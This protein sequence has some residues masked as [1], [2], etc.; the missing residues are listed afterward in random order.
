MR[1]PDLDPATRA[2]RVKEGM[3]S[4]LLFGLFGAFGLE[5]INRMTF[6]ADY[7]ARGLTSHS[8]GQV[9]SGEVALG[10]RLLGAHLV[11][12][13]LQRGHSAQLSAL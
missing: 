1:R 11:H 2:V 7:E 9:L 6:F 4:S 12:K 3:R 8:S 10:R 5:W 13:S